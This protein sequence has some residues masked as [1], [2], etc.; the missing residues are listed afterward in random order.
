M[1]AAP[2][3][4]Q[5]TNG[6][7]TTLQSR[8]LRASGRGVRASK[9]KRK[10]VGGTS[11]MRKF[12]TTPTRTDQCSNVQ[13]LLNEFTTKL[14][15]LNGAIFDKNNSQSEIVRILDLYRSRSGFY[16]TFSYPAT[17]GQFCRFWNR[18]QIYLFYPQTLQ[19]CCLHLVRPFQM[20]D[21]RTQN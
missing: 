9:E 11:L 5:R 8:H 19:F 15:K 6:A 16:K 7:L 10:E 4:H 21:S 13:Q 17:F 18:T 3:P 14:S 12:P 1:A 20:S 2:P